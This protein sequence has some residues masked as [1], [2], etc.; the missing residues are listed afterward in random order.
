MVRR[1][2][3]GLIE[4]VAL[5]AL[6]AVGLERG[7]GI[8]ALGTWLGYSAAVGTGALTGLVAGKPIWRRDAK[9]EAGLKAF[10][11]AVV[12]AGLYFAFRRWGAVAVDLGPLGAGPLPDVP[13]A[14]LPLVGTVLALLFELDDA[15]S[16][17]EQRE[18]E[19]RA[20]TDKVRID[21]SDALREIAALEDEL[22]PNERKARR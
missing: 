4:G 6:V 18:H 9:T 21:D 19:E 10:A 12:A 13:L 15:P 2:V 1:L 16:R 7:L 3:L 5:G 17:A 11:G 14:V 8:E 20:R 22:T